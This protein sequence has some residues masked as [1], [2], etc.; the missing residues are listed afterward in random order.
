MSDPCHR[1]GDDG[2]ASMEAA[3]QV[4]FTAAALPLIESYDWYGNFGHF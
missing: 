3:L 1:Y 4:W 2:F